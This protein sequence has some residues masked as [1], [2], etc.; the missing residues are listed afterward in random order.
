[1]FFCFPASE[2][3]TYAGSSD[4]RKSRLAPGVPTAGSPDVSR[5]FRCRS[6]F[7]TAASSIL[8]VPHHLTISFTRPGPFSYGYSL[9]PLPPVALNLS[10]HAAIAS[11]HAAASRSAHTSGMLGAPTS[12]PSL[13]AARGL[14]GS[15][16][17]PAPIPS[18]IPWHFLRS[19]WTFSWC[20]GDSVGGRARFHRFVRGLWI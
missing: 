9:P 6:G 14:A 15:P 18:P 17:L 1:M 20:G 10:P 8:T 11:P 19:W 16:D 4:V 7:L 12:I 3:L 13:Y 5:E 2:V